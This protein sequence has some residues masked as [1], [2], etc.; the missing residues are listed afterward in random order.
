MLAPP[1][2]LR[3]DL[4]GLERPGLVVGDQAKISRCC[5]AHHLAADITVTV[6][7]HDMIGCYHG[8]LCL[9]AG[10]QRCRDQQNAK[11]TEHSG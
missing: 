7:G 10:Q 9:Q 11:E 3:G 4:Q 2:L 6:C 8:L 5:C 1:A